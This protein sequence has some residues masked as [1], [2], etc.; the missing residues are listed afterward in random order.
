MYFTDGRT[1]LEMYDYCGDDYRDD[2]YTETTTE[3][4]NDISIKV[5]MS[6]SIEEAY[7]LLS[8]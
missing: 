7:K 6:E 8:E 5:L 2:S 4:L 1:D 3:E